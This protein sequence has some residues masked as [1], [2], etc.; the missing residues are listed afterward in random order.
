MRI[1]VKAVNEKSLLVGLAQKG[2]PRSPS[3][4]RRRMRRN[5]QGKKW[6]K[7]VPGRGN[8]KG[9]GGTELSRSKEFGKQPR[10]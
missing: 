6:G 2:F 3:L 5:Y 1:F 4:G 7:S 10:G 9:S 8:S